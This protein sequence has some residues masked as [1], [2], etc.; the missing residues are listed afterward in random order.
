MRL[1]RAGLRMGI[2]HRFTNTDLE[3]MRGLIICASQGTLRG[4]DRVLEDKLRHF[5]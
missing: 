3:N 5:G 2:I 4:M 1:L